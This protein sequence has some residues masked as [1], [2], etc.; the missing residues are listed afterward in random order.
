MSSTGVID[1]KGGDNA[2]TAKS[3]H[4]NTSE[5][6]YSGALSFMRRR[7]S[8][9]LNG[10]DVAVTGIPYDLATSS[11]PGTR[12]GPQGVRRASTNLAWAPHFPSGRDIFAELAVIDYGDMVIDPGHPEKL[13]AMIEDH[14][15]DIVQSGTKML[16][17]GGDHFITYPILKA[18]AEKYGDGISL[19]QFDAHS[20]TW[21]DDGDRIDHGTMFWHAAKKGIVNP[22]KSIQVGIRTHNESAHGYNIIYGPEVQ[23]MSIDA[24]VEQIKATVGNNPAYIT[25]DI[26]GLDPCYAPGTGTPVL[27]GLTS[28]QAVSILRGLAGHVN[29]IGSDVVEVSPPFD[30]SDITSLAGATMAWEMLNI[31]AVNRAK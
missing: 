24:I 22:S 30:V 6:M 21:E 12:L 19:I 27:G 17:I 20:D 18:H 3:V 29:L 14:A 28:H 2:F 15:R 13:P 10:I 11:R 5:P 7:Y 23:S 1:T 9:D 8:R 25:F 31:H 4:Q 16:T 26:D